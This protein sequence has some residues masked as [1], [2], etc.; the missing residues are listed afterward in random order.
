MSYV[1]GQN[2]NVFKVGMA[3]APV[4]DWRYYDSIYTERYMLTPQENHEGY[5]ITYIFRIL[6]NWWQLL[7]KLESNTKFNF[8]LTRITDLLV[9][10]QQIICIIC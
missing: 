2:S 5:E 10:G 7:P 1:L 3:V 6:H 8:T 9:V 4:I